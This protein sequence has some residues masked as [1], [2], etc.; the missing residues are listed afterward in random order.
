MKCTKLKKITPKYDDS[1]LKF[2]NKS[3]TQFI[4]DSS[5]YVPSRLICD[6]FYDDTIYSIKICSTKI[7]KTIK[8]T[9]IE[10]QHLTG[11]KLTIIGKVDLD[12]IFREKDNKKNIYKIYKSIPFNTFIVVPEEVCECDDITILYNV[13]DIDIVAVSN[14]KI[15]ISI[16]ILLKYED[17][18]E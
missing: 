4:V 3:F 6:Y 13:E 2:K 8:G 1:S 17:V 18:K 5:E 10:G 14:N 16:M 12:I 7:I 9:S 11:K 15:F